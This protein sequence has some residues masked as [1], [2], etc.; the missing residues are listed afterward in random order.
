M[1]VTVGISFSFLF[2]AQ[3]QVSSDRHYLTKGGKPFFW[4][5][6]TAWELFHR[7]NREEAKIYL[8]NRADKGFT[9]IQAVAIAELDGANVSN[10]YGDK[11]LINGDPAKPNEAYFRQV[12]FVIDEAN[13]L[14]LVVALLPTWG[15][16]WN[17]DTWGKGPEIFTPENAKIYGSWIAQ[18]YKNKEIIWVLGGDRNPKTDMHYAIIRAMAAGIREVVKD[19]Q[20][21]TYH[22][23]GAASSFDFFADDDWIDIHMS[24]TGH[25]AGSPDYKVNSKAREIIIIRPHVNGEPNYED[26]PNDFKPVEKGWMDDF[27]TREAAYWNMLSGGA[28]HTY[29]NHNIWQ[30]YDEKYEPI[31]N[32]RTFWQ[33]AMN[34]PGAYQVGFM[35]RKLKK[36]NWQ[37]L[38]MD[39]SLIIGDNPEGLQYKM[40]ALSA[41]GDFMMVYIPYG[42]KTVVNMAKI[43]ATRLQAW[44]FNPRDGRTISLGSF[45]NSGTKEFI[46]TAV[47][48]GSDWLLIIDDISKHYPDPQ[49]G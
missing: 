27:D 22:T 9:V 37:N 26:H 3:I 25:Y 43:K 35:R 13:K 30:F 15:D 33:F 38:A 10:A 39:Q 1:V 16:K 8:K 14:G 46:P 44:W 32:A 31:N 12:D 19:K 42:G 36:R 7:L 20:L 47:G 23:A 4:L 2:V 40:A 28:G 41:N 21:I 49:A 24:Q 45:D 17:K 18:R 34:Y 48:R 5:G 29:G 6:D 11:A